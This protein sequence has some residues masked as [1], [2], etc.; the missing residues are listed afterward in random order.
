MVAAFTRATA[1][2]LT[3]KNASPHD[4][5]APVMTMTL[6]Q[7]SASL[8][9][10]SID[11]ATVIEHGATQADH[12]AR[13]LGLDPSAWLVAIELHARTLAPLEGVSLWSVT[14]FVVPPLV[15]A[16]GDDARLF[17]QLLNAVTQTLQVL[18]QHPDA[19][20][21]FEQYAVRLAAQHL[22]PA[23]LRVVFEAA[24][25]LARA[26]IDP[27][28][29]LQVLAEPTSTIADEAAF[30]R[31]WQQLEHTAL[32]L[33]KAGLHV[34]APIATGM[35]AM[36]SN[37]QAFLGSGD[38]LNRCLS[39]L[40]PLMQGA[41]KNAYG[42]AEY[43]LAGLFTST[44]DG[45]EL[46]DAM[47][48]ALTMFDHGLEPGPTLREGLRSPLHLDVATRLAREGIDPHFVCTQGVAHFEALGWLDD[49]GERL[50]QLALEL[51][52]HAL[53]VRLLFEDGLEVLPVLEH[54]HHGQALRALELAEAMA[55]RG[56]D[57]GV[58][59]RWSLPHALRAVSNHE[60]GTPSAADLLT[61]A[62]ALVEQNVDPSAA[63]SYGVR[64][65]AE[66][67][68]DD[69][70][71]FASLSATVVSLMARLQGLGL[72]LQ[73][74][75]FHD[76]PALAEAGGHSQAF[77]E[78]L[79]RTA[80]LV[81]EWSAKKFDVTTLLAQG[82]P[83]AA[84]EAKGK[85][86]VLAAALDAALRLG[87]EH[88][89][90]DALALL[91]VGL[92][93]ALSAAAN[94]EVGFRRA[95][96]SVEARYAQL[97]AAL[98]AQASM[99][100]AALAGTDVERLDASLQVLIA[101]SARHGQ[102]VI[103]LGP[104]LSVLA[105][106]AQTPAGLGLLIDEALSAQALVPSALQSAFVDRGISLIK[107]SCRAVPGQPKAFE[108][109]RDLLQT[110]ARWLRSETQ[111][112]VLLHSDSL[113]RF[114]TPSRLLALL[115]ALAPALAAPPPVRATVLPLLELARD[116]DTWLDMLAVL[117]PLLALPN[118]PPAFLSGLAQ[119]RRLLGAQP[120]LWSTL[121]GPTLKTAK[122]HA[123]SLLAAFAT[124]GRHLTRDEDCDVLR[125]LVTQRGVRAADD[126][127]NLIVPALHEGTMPSLSAHRAVL[128]RYLREVG[129][130]DTSVYAHFLSLVEDA[131][132]TEP[133]RTQKIAALTADLETLNQAIHR[134]T[135]TAELEA[136][137]LFFV[138]LQHVFPPAI[139][140]T[141]QTYEQLYQTLGDRPG[142][143]ALLGGPFENPAPLTVAAGSWQLREGTIDVQPFEWLKACLPA[144][145][146]PLEADSTLGWDLVTAW[147][148]GRLAREQVRVPLLERLLRGVPASERPPASTQSAAQL[149]AIRDL[150][151][152]ALLG[153]VERALLAARALDAPRF[154]RLVRTK[155]A[156]PPRVG[157]G[158]VKAVS[159]TL[160]A[161]RA[162][163]LDRAE[164]GARLA[165][166]L[167]VFETTE[168]NI[169]ELLD[170]PASAVR[171]ALLALPARS[172]ELEP[173]KEVGRVHGE[174]I[175][176]QLQGMNEVLA[177][178]L[179]YRASSETLRLRV[180]V[181]KRRA[182]AAVGLAEGVCVARD[183]A[184]WNSPNFL[185]A[186]I[187]NEAGVCL[188]G[189]HLLTVVDEGGTYL[190]L[191]GI[192]PA[193]S[194][195]ERVD[196][197]TLLRTLLDWASGLAKQCGLAGVWVPTATVIHSNRQA[198]SLALA[199]QRLAVRHTKQHQFSF[200]PWAYRFDEVYVVGTGG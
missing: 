60:G 145:D 193:L 137:P 143:V 52:R 123:G 106:F 42:L 12:H 19:A 125:A 170:T 184:L 167:Q 148:E 22:R 164:A 172:V 173:G 189:L 79:G 187:W 70:A 81:E 176:Q 138:A 18:H 182:H 161:V 158:L 87:R 5:V 190:A 154:E 89:P 140:A 142:D 17:A 68:H 84:R 2:P 46:L 75:L 35:A 159:R 98:T 88:R 33:A 117:P 149:L 178:E 112:Q 14:H 65:L 31:C 32:A 119:V 37:S 151:A 56:L 24:H 102:A 96:A 192:N 129:F 136:H 11:A 25:R 51:H 105:E 15:K 157:P 200:S 114:A 83:R 118:A 198:I 110:L 8:T 77:V 144:D 34:G 69:A 153:L 29:F 115:E 3:S 82:L 174:L 85:P 179:A 50:V 155:L 63:L 80:T 26:G 147:S 127:W 180:E 111:A 91:E 100:A 71:T 175:G 23:R 128:Q 163:T 93:T 67:S 73:E 86:W 108:V 197:G 101:A 191:P 171:A 199:Q 76:V 168:E 196:A 135:V 120:R 121:I 54:Q 48:L 72:D 99:A 57:P 131:S 150:A 188:G 28:W 122:Q 116:E 113:G 177:H 133:L 55:R 27:G 64:A 30:E 181:T 4:E 39:A 21:R 13:S 104:A 126:V 186:V 134:G 94:D 58:T 95:L 166:Q 90:N 40:V 16:A 156:P 9:A 152:D 47:K 6:A 74:V 66:L 160:E 7:L 103:Q 49:G 169:N 162:Q 146:A 78:L 62:H 10:A 194:L 139:S 36:V 195:L 59:M 92:S 61:L 165:A 124:I 38:T 107:K 109:G 141:R 185:Q 41:G 132:L 53:R 44:L 1:S 20:T 183:E 45:D 97:P 43:G 130:A